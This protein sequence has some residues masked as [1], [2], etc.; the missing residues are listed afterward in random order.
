MTPQERKLVDD[1]F[2]RLAKLETSPRDADAENAIADGWERAPNAAYALVQSVIVQEEALKRANERIQELESQLG[3][4]ASPPATGGGFLDS[5]RAAMQGGRGSVPSVRAG[6]PAASEP[7]PSKW[8][9][10]QAESRWNASQGETQSNSPSGGAY[11]QQPG[12]YPQPNPPQ[13]GGGSFLGTAASTAAGVVGGALLMGGIRSLFGQHGGARASAF[14]P[15]LSGDRGSS[16]GGSAAN[17]DL[18]R[19]A[20]LNDIGRA[21]AGGDQTAFYS[22]GDSDGGDDFADNGDFDAGDFGGDTTDT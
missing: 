12:G 15:G 19:D 9:T 13:S 21:G 6:A 4:T 18:A 3:D 22:G 10:G 8:N 5:A 20:G 11:S 14:D 7:A 2:D 1:L 16:W 17:S